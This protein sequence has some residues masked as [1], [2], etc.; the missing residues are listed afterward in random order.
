MTLALTKA[1]TGVT[2]I[3]STADDAGPTSGLL[4][5]GDDEATLLESLAC[6]GQFDTGDV[7]AEDGGLVFGVETGVRQRRHHRVAHEMQRGLARFRA[8]RVGRLA[9]ADDGGVFEHALSFLP[10]SMLAS[11][12]NNSSRRVRYEIRNPRRHA[13]RLGRGDPHG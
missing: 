1:V 13:D 10:P 7:T 4:L 12:N 2:E 6:G 9:D 11:G 8:P 3:S 5:V